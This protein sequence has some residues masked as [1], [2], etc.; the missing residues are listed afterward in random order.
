[1]ARHETENGR[2]AW[3][4]NPRQVQDPFVL[5]ISQLDPEVAKR[6]GIEPGAPVPTLAPFAHIGIELPEREDVEAVA[7]KARE[8]GT[9]M[10]EPREMPEHIGYICAVRDPDGNIVEFS[11]NQKVYAKIREMWAEQHADATTA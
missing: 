2:G 9:L 3:L 10:W 11:W 5:V 6:F 7:E 8:M 1:V 4:S